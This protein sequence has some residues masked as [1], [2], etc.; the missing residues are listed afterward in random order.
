MKRRLIRSRSAVEWKT[1]VLVGLGLLGCMILLIIRPGKIFGYP[2]T[3]SPERS[4]LSN[5]K[6]MGLAHLMYMEDNDG[7]GPPPD[8]WME[9]LLPYYKN[10]RILN[11]PGLDGDAGEYG[12]AYL[13][14]LGP[15]RESDVINPESV[16]AFFNSSDLRR[17]VTGGLELLPDPPRWDGEVNHIAFLDAH[18]KAFETAP[19]FKIELP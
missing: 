1:M 13:S 19:K 16:P 7:Y 18:A 5:L 2:N 10:E 15:I 14:E 9:V 12:Y 4:D 8:Q 3:H 17:N 6:Q 11:S